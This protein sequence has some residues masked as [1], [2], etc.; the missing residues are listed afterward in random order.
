VILERV[1][2]LTSNESDIIC[3]PFAG[4]GVTAYVAERLNRRWVVADIN[5]CAAIQER[6][7]SFKNG[8][9]PL[10]KV[11]EPRTQSIGTAT[12]QTPSKEYSPPAPPAALP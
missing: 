1:I 12:A 4:G 9:H 6:L 5:D 10:W 7:T 8:S 2:K 3:D 11:P